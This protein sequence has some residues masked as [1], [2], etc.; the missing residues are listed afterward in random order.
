MSSA[1]FPE[2]MWIA[3]GAHPDGDGACVME[4]VSLLAGGAKT[5]HPGCTNPLIAAAA[6]TVN[7]LLGDEDR[8]RLAP[9]VPRLALATVSGPRIDVALA[10]WCGRGI[11][12]LCRPPTRPAAEAAV[13]AAAEWLAGRGSEARCRAAAVDAADAAA[14]HDDRWGYAAANV[15]S[16]AA[17]SA[18][19]AADDG[20]RPVERGS[21]PGHDFEALVGAA[22]RGAA[23]RGDDLVS[24]LEALV[25]AHGSAAVALHAE[26]PPARAGWP[27]VGAFEG[28]EALPV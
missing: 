13:L 1:A 20:A 22:I 16:A 6:I 4:W 14:R 27:L 28:L 25:D 23:R 12:P 15:A 21:G 2:A 19:A 7:D 3:K 5:D 10:V 18:A 11:L 9:L 17:D 26:R 24:W 8:Q